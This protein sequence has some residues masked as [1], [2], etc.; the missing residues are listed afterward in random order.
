M[1]ERKALNVSLTP[2]LHAFVGELVRSG[3]YGNHSEVVRAGLRLLQHEERRRN[4][5]TDRCA[6]ASSVNLA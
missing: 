6:A 4:K 2:E 1:I 3:S 5:A